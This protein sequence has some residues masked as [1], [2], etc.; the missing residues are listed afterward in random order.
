MR[1]DE[2]LGPKGMQWKEDLGFPGG[3]TLKEEK[4]LVCSPSSKELSSWLW[5]ER[6]DW[7]DWF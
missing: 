3:N 7:I 1:D 5:V 4:K 2:E 6:L